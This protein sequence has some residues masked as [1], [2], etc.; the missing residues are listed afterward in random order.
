MTN[1]HT[2]QRS[3]HKHQRS[4]LVPFG[5]D[6]LPKALLVVPA[7]G[8]QVGFLGPGALLSGLEWNPHR[9]AL[10]YLSLGKGDRAWS[11]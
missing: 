10:R 3:A 2:H 11:T 9:R 4:R 5:S 8:D 7:S 6:N 1:I